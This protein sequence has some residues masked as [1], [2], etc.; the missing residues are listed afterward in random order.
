MARIATQLMLGARLA[1]INPARGIISHYGVKEAVFPFNMLP[2]VDPLLGPEMRSTGEVLGMGS[3]F[4]EAF[5][6]AQEAARPALPLSGTVLITVAQKD[7]AG[8]VSIAREFHRLG[9]R[10]LA[11]SGTSAHLALHGIRS[12]VVN[13]MHEGRPHIADLVKNREIDL[14]INTPAGK[15]SQYDD[16]YIRKNAIKYRVP[17]ITTLAGAVA[18]AKGIAAC[19]GGIPGEMKSLQQYHAEIRYNPEPDKPGPFDVAQEKT[20]YA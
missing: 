11:T 16:S 13:K 6:K 9:F 14:I 1:D 19:S 10:I 15:Q 12:Q 20:A 17:Y 18:A 7:R 8:V 3:T 5:F 2:E 4:G